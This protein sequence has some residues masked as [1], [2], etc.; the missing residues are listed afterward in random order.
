[1]WTTEDEVNLLVSNNK[2][3]K[4][5]EVIEELGGMIS[6]DWERLPRKR[7]EEIRG[8]LNYICQTY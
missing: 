2:W 3:A 5:K 4:I 8:Y 1:M 6:K 7:L